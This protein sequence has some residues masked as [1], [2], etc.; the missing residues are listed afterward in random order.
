M[1]KSKMDKIF[2]LHTLTLCSTCLHRFN[3]MEVASENLTIKQLDPW[4][5]C[6]A[7]QTKFYGDFQCQRPPLHQASSPQIVFQYEYSDND[8]H[9]VHTKDKTSFSSHQLH[10]REVT[11]KRKW[12]FL[13]E[14]S[15][16]KW[17]KIMSNKGR[18]GLT[19]KGNF[20]LNFHFVFR[21]T[22]FWF[23]S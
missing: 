17:K 23:L 20:I 8:V 21:I 2:T 15:M 7:G 3:K 1:I 9:T 10:L 18:G 12:E 4:N 16:K 13:M 11:R 5:M 14:F 19:L 6:D 22:L